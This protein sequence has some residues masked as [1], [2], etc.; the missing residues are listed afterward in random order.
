[1]TAFRFPWDEAPVRLALRKLLALRAYMRARSVEDR[2]D[3]SIPEAAGLTEAQA[4]E[5]Y[6]V[7]AI[8]NYED[9]FVIPTASRVPS[10][11]HPSPDGRSSR[12]PN[13]I[14]RSPSVVTE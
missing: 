5:M 3:P 4:E 10:G 7:M 1:M 13:S 8:A 9:R 14:V 11:I 12:S 6:R 2:R